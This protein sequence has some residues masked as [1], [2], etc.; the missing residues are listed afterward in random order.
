MN[1]VSK[2]RATFKSRR[3]PFLSAVH[4]IKKGFFTYTAVWVVLGWLDIKQRYRR[5]VLGP[6]WLTISTSVMV[7]ALGLVYSGLFNQPLKDYLPYLAVGMIVWTLLSTL[8]NEA[9]AVFIM[10]EGMIKQVR[11]PL[12]VHVLR[13]VWRNIIIFFHNAVVLIFVL[14][15]FSRGASAALF[16]IPF[17]L[18]IIALNGLWL[19][20]ILGV[21]CSRF[22]DIAPIIANFTQLVFFITP[23]FW[24]PEALVN[25]A[26]L[27][28]LNPFYHFIEIVRSPLL[29]GNLPIESWE[30]VISIT[31]LLGVLAVFVLTKYRHRVAYWV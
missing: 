24:R 11:M 25:R 1:Q 30:V 19:G 16:L 20:L 31:I 28:N 4:D 8:L 22:R 9:C 10:A 26:W 21:F 3:S 18:I 13:M 29:Q 6:F 23:I 12:T 15:F 17:A 5:S 7:A 27:A 2:L 14:L